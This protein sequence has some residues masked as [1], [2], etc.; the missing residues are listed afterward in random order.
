MRATTIFYQQFNKKPFP[1]DEELE[2]MVEI[3]NCDYETL[4]V[5]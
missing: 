3:C 4:K 1:T 2:K 5:S